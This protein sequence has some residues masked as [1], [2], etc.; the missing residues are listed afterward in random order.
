[1]HILF[2]IP[3]PIE[4]AP[5]Q[6]FRFEQYFEILKKKGWGLRIYSFIDDHT[7]QILYERGH[8]FSKAYGILKGF[9][10]RFHVLLIVKKYDYVYIH[11]EA[12]PI[13]PPISEWIISKIIRKRVIYD[14]DD[15]VWM[16]DTSENNKIISSIKCH[17]KVSMICKWAYKVSCGNEFLCDYAKRFNKNVI[18]NPSTIDNSHIHS[19]IKDH[20][21]DKVI[22]GWTGSHS[23]LE[24]LDIILPVI[25]KLETKYNFEFWIISNKKPKFKLRSLVL[26]QWQKSTEVS[27]LLNLDIGLMPLNDDEWAKGKCGLKAL[28]YMALGIPPVVSPVGVNKSIVD[29]KVDGYWCETSDDWYYYLEKLILDPGLR[30]EIGKCARDKVIKHYSVTSNKDNFLSLFN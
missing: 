30:T 13:G 27:D 4:S 10:R 28:Q 11:R 22:I 29:H 18:L 23:T 25:R 1:M 26:V 14:F 7:W 3:Y 15:A 2:I 20:N 19:K 16:T 24:Y 5:S 21:T 6:R 17:W 9:I 12:T 8:I